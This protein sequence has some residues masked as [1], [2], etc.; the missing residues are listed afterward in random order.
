MDYSKLH[1]P[2]GHWHKP[3]TVAAP[4]QIPDIYGLM[5]NRTIWG[6]HFENDVLSF[7]GY[8]HS[9]MY[10]TAGLVTYEGDLL[11][12]AGT[13]ANAELRRI[14]S[15][16]STPYNDVFPADGS[17]QFA[18][19]AT[20]YPFNDYD[21]PSPGTN[22][23]HALCVDSYG[24]LVYINTEG[25]IVQLSSPTS[26]T[27][28]GYT[29]VVV[30]GTDGNLYINKY[31]YTRF[32]WHE[33]YYPVTGPYWSSFWHLIPDGLND[34]PLT[35]FGTDVTRHTA[36][37]TWIDQ[38]I[39]DNYIYVFQ[40]TSPN[41]P[42]KIY[43]RSTYALKAVYPNVTGTCGQ[44]CVYGDSVY[45]GAG[46]FSGCTISRFSSSTLALQNTAS[47]SNRGRLPA[48]AVQCGHLIVATDGYTTSTTPGIY[49][50]DLNSLATVGEI[51]YDSADSLA[52][53]TCIIAL[54]EPY[55]AVAGFNRITVYDVDS[56]V[57]VDSINS[58]SK[59]GYGYSH[60]ALTTIF[61]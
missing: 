37:A 55:V 51:M 7:L 11:T 56:M 15:V 4:T 60:N 12:V 40:S 27:S 6:V 18:L 29:S 32:L 46:V 28:R 59:L 10:P 21:V 16:A 14:A 38:A 13:L 39:T 34:G 24:R 47:L 9:D 49:K 42:V 33:E 48:L 52:G 43:D 41:A 54:Q 44:M 58:P 57:M 23:W 26:R 53:N 19:K 2:C 61:R 20:T 8:Y 3:V 1:F 17:G 30:T 45:C 25:Y 50:L 31:V 5:R 35:I 36:S 22:A